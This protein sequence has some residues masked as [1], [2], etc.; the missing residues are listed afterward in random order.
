VRHFKATC[1]VRCDQFA[2]RH[3][4]T[5]VG[6]DPAAFDGLPLSAVAKLVQDSPPFCPKAKIVVTEVGRDGGEAHA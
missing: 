3:C 2:K 4:T 1:S 5:R 6:A